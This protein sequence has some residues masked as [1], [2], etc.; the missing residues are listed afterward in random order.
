MPVTFVHEGD[1]IDYTPAVAKTAGDVVVQGDLIGVVRIDIAANR[2]GALALEGVFD[3]PKAGGVAF[4]TGQKTYWDA[5]N[6]IASSDP[7]VGRLLGRVVKDAVS[8]DTAVRILLDMQAVP[9]LLYSAEVASSLITNTVAE[10]DFDKSVTIPAG[11]LQVGDVIRVR[12]EVIAISTNSTDTLTIRLK[13]GATV[14]VVTAA[15]DVANNDIGYVEAD[16]VVRTVG[17]GGTIV[18]CGVQALGTEGTVTAKPFK[19]ASTAIDTTVA[20]TVKASAQW[21]VANAGNQ[22]R[23]DV[24]DVELLRKL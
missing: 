6:L 5:T 15:V 17:A 20:Q 10:T 7:S 11:T 13:I 16:V 24:L 22:V 1:A 23:L 2:L 4:T 3:F 9:A 14:I 21:S 12:G 19:L 8:A 18:A